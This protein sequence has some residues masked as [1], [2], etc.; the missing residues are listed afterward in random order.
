MELKPALRSHT[1]HDDLEGRLTLADSRF[2]PEEGAPHGTCVTCGRVLD[3][4]TD[5]RAHLDET[6]TE[7]H[8]HRVRIGNPSRPSRIEAALESLIDHA[9]D[10]V[11][12]DIQK[13]VDDG[14]LTAEEAQV[15]LSRHD[16][17]SDGWR[18]WVDGKG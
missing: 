16:D 4:E 1:V 7:G 14:Q 9:I 3:T 12:D 10:D 15:A 13:L 17:F 11:M 18:A 8:S 6:L 2:D 5:V